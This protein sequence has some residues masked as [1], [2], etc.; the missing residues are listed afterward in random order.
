MVNNHN[1]RGLFV[2]VCVFA[3]LWL[4]VAC[5]SGAAA[6]FTQTVVTWTPTWQACANQPTGAK[7]KWQRWGDAFYSSLLILHSDCI[8]KIDK[9]FSCFF[10]CF[11]FCLSAFHRCWP[12]RHRSSMSC[13]VTLGAPSNYVRFAQRGIK[14]LASNHVAIS[15][16][17]HASQDGR[18]EKL[19]NAKYWHNTITDIVHSVLWNRYNFHWSIF[20][21]F[22]R[23]NT[24]SQTSRPCFSSMCK[25][26]EQQVLTFDWELPVCTRAHI[27]LTMSWPHLLKKMFMWGRER[28]LHCYSQLCSTFDSSPVLMYRHVLFFVHFEV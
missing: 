9:C 11:F 25:G 19:W 7:S 10:F 21:Q 17:K 26:T 14:I 1:T 13:T 6:T 16:A 20:L 5:V 4:Q 2:S 15:C 12:C 27:P 24:V 8:V 3:C 18:Y 28:E 22:L 23:N